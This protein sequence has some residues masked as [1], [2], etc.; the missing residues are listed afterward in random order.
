MQHCFVIMMQKGIFSWV[1]VFNC[2]VNFCYLILSAF[3]Q[4]LGRVYS[5]FELLWEFKIIYFGKLKLPSMFSGCVYLSRKFSLL[6]FISLDISLRPV[7]QSSFHLM[8]AFAQWH[9]VLAE[10][11]QVKFRLTETYHLKSIFHTNKQKT[12]LHV[13]L[14]VLRRFNFVSRAVIL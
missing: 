2:V 10:N 8:L 9:F 14:G 3:I 7:L 4:R 11:N 13:S 12:T 5:F 6:Y 1:A